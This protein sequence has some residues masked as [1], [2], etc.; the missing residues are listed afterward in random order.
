MYAPIA[1]LFAKS[2][3]SAD[4]RLRFGVVSH[5][6]RSLS[7]GG[8]GSDATGE[9]RPRAYIDCVTSG[10]RYYVCWVWQ[11]DWSSPVSLSRKFIKGKL[12]YQ[13]E[14]ER[15][16]FFARPFKFI[17]GQGLLLPPGAQL[18]ESVEEVIGND[19]MKLNCNV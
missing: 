18:E 14:G 5:P 12:V 3:A 1:A 8:N 17:D 2:G 4:G 16:R 6:A 11:E 7:G 10:V 9:G 15:G 13:R 19:Q